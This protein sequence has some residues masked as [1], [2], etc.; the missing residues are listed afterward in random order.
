[1]TK[2]VEFLMDA[3]DRLGDLESDVQETVMEVTSNC[4]GQLI[5]LGGAAITGKVGQYIESMLERLSE[6]DVLSSTVALQM[7]SELAKN[8]PT[9]FNPYVEKFAAKSYPLLFHDNPILRHHTLEA[10]KAQ[11]SF[12]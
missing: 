7:L 2:L 12:F 5:K 9:R 10:F 4:F 8:A 11:T 1:M 3:L 6:S